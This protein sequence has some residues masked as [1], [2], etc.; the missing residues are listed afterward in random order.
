L[1]DDLD[2]AA[3]T[4]TRI[5]VTGETGVGKELV[6][7]EIHRRSS[8]RSRP[9]VAVN[10]AGLAE[11]LLE[12]ELFGHVRGSFT[13]AHRDKP[14]KFELADG[15]TLF[16]DEVGEM[17]ARMQGLLL[18]VLETGELQ[19]VGA[20]RIT[21]C[22]DVRV[23]AAT[24]R[25]LDALVQAGT[26]RMDLYYRLNVL[27][28][29]VPPLRQRDGD[30]RLLVDHFVS[31]WI[32]EVGQVR[33][34]APSTYAV[35][36]AYSWPGNIRQ[37][38]NVV[39][40]MLI[41]SNEELIT[42]AHVPPDLPGAAPAVGVSTSARQSERPSPAE[43]LCSQMERGASFWDVVYTPFIAHDLTREDV[44]EVI[45]R[46][47][48]ATHG[49]YS[50]MVKRFNVAPADYKKVLSFLRRHKCLLEYREF[51][52]PGGRR[53]HDHALRPVTRSQPRLG[54]M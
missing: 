43:F 8:R 54:G 28:L 37:L 25:D 36:E 31:R 19:K 20:D 26:F 33:R 10:C 7:T 5:L 24:N 13:G 17:T 53:G 41:T 29:R 23:I 15:G 32:R 47:L 11:S 21:R 48:T 3:K 30:V 39:Q 4:S 2:R 50:T 45:R 51:R 42:P 52:D 22:R 35:L 38:E 6:A 1:L 44:I 18:R 34:L 16:L 27:D 9:F 49:H 14:G 46:G 12:S 40:R